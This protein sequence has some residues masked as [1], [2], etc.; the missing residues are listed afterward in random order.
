M[1]RCHRCS[2]VR[3]T[4]SSA[5]ASQSS[6]YGRGA[7]LAESAEK[8][9]RLV[10]ENTPAKARLLPTSPEVR[11]LDRPGRLRT[12]GSMS[13]PARVSLLVVISA[14]VA[15]A[16]FSA[17]FDANSRQAG[18]ALN[19]GVCALRLG[20]ADEAGRWFA[21]AAAVD[22]QR[23]EA[24]VNLAVVRER[25]GDRDG[26][27]RALERAVELRPDDPRLRERLRGL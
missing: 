7:S 20:R 8:I 12:F 1:R 3:N 22:P 27:R 13:S 23:F 2:V 15:L 19:A 18:S 16:A 17:A 4:L 11:S 24:W 26:A 25:Q 9:N 10:F 14:S 21:R 6:G 5:T